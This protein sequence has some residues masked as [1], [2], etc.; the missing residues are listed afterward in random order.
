MTENAKAP[1]TTTGETARNA[2]LAAG[3]E[4]IRHGAE[5]AHGTYFHL[6]RHTDGRALA[7][8]TALGTGRFVAAQGRNRQAWNTTRLAA[9]S[10]PALVRLL[11]G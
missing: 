11:E 2:A 1:H 3:F 5:T 10:I 9:R 8:R 7:L 6:Y 4:L